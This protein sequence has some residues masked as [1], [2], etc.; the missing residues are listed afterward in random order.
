[1]T[2]GRSAPGGGGNLVAVRGTLGESMQPQR[3][4]QRQRYLLSA[5]Q[6]GGPKVDERVAMSVGAGVGARSELVYTAL[7]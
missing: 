6:Q 5:R 7:P 2:S 4:L 3:A 1:M